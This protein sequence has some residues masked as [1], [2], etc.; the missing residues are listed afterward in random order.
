MKW[1]GKVNYE[2]E[3]QVNGVDLSEFID[4]RVN[5]LLVEGD[6]ITLIYDDGSNTLTISGSVF[7]SD[8]D[9]VSSEGQST[10]TGN[11]N[12]QQKVSLAA[13][14]LTVSAKYRIGFS[15]ELTS[16]KDGQVGAKSRIQI[17][18]TTTIHQNTQALAKDIMDGDDGV[19]Y[20]YGGFYYHTATSSSHTID[21]DYTVDSSQAGSTAYI[22]RARLEIWRVS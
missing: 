22:R 14:G 10:H 1:K 19:W 9:E 17:D 16:N 8:F 7:G 2:T 13:T 6:N 4:D 11:S 5:T 3:P 12:W 21:L 18:D 15:F 20:Q